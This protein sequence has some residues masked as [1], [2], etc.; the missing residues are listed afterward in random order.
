MALRLT[1]LQKGAIIAHAQDETR[2]PA[3]A[4]ECCGILVGL[5]DRVTSVIR[6]TNV[7]YSPFTYTMD[8]D[9]VLRVQLEADRKGLEILGFYHSHLNS[10]PVPSRTD[11]RKASIAWP[12]AIHVIV[13]LKDAR[14]PELRAF[15]IDED[16]TYSAE[17][18]VE[19]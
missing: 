10:D 6:V 8:G 17:E 12:G 1:Q 9:E 7:D 19:E 13:S 11:V 2:D 16:E 14:R 18:I 3:R 15:R 4:Y 5:G